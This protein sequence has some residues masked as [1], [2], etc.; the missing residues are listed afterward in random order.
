M[1][2]TIRVWYREGPEPNVHTGLDAQQ[3]V[4]GAGAFARDMA[5][6]EGE[7]VRRFEITCEPE[8]G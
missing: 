3:I 4:D 2:Y 7:G 8:I 1:T 5:M 6:L